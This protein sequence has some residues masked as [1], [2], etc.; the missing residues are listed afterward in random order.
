MLHQLLADLA[1]IWCAQ[2][3]VNL[4]TETAL[5]R[6]RVPK[7]R[8][9][10]LAQELGEKLAQVSWAELSWAELL[11]WRWAELVLVVLR[12]CVLLTALSRAGHPAARENL[13]VC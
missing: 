12:G 7:A 9:A 1:S 11:V 6:V 3:S 8:R 13:W 10:A 4:A 5:V 2:A